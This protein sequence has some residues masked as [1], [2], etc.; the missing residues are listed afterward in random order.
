MLS[1]YLLNY[2]FFSQDEKASLDK[3]ISR[4]WQTMKRG[5]SAAGP[6]HK[7]RCYSVLNYIVAA[8][9]E[10]ISLRA[11]LSRIHIRGKDYF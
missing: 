1:L 10:D 4:L 9:D 6:R 3:Q 5:S 8:I 7:D 2:L 11:E